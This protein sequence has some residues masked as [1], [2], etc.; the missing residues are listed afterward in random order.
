MFLG[1]VDKSNWIVL[2]VQSEARI[3][4]S[5]LMKLPAFKK[6]LKQMKTLKERI[7]NSEV[8]ITASGIDFVPEVGVRSLKSLDKDHLQKEEDEN[9][10]LLEK[11]MTKDTDTGYWSCK[12][13][14]WIGQARH[15]AKSHARICGQR[16]RNAKKRSTG[17]KFHCSYK[18]CGLAFSLKEK[19]KTHYR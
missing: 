7:L 12:D 17:L 1:I 15:K 4:T 11:L 19:L 9:L 5:S 2:S 18:D 6:G 13:C 14:D 10:Q 8:G 3:K 16:R